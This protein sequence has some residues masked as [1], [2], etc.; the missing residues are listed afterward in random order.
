MSY[1]AEDLLAKAR[2]IHRFYAEGA[3]SLAGEQVE[4]GDEIGQFIAKIESTDAAF[5]RELSRG[6]VTAIKNLSTR[7][8]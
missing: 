4:A 1:P 6:K 7:P 2:F 8:P 3:P 5:Q